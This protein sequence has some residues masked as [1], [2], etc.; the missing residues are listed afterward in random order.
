ER[1]HEPLGGGG[2]SYRKSVA[3][4]PELFE[5]TKA[6]MRALRYTG[7]AMAEFKID[8]ERKTHVFLEINA[9]FWGSLPL[10]IAAGAD[11]PFWLY[12]PLVA[13]RRD[14][15]QRY[16]EGIYARNWIGDLKW[17]AANLAADRS[18]PTLMTRP[19]PLV[20]AEL[21]HV[22]GGRERSDTFVAD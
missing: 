5:A 20:A 12:E 4:D 1:V 6:L 7:V 11:F 9:R 19:L 2:S 17:M 10:A 16:T 22:I 8:P 15:P 14:F 18:D 3:L 13:G 21:A